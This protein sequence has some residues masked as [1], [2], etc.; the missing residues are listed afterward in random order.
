MSNDSNVKKGTEYEQFVQT[1][2]QSILVAEGVENIVVQH[3]IE[4]TGRSGCTHQMDVY[5]E[6]R[7]AGQ[8]YRTAIECKAF[9]QDV[10]IGRVR[11]FHGVLVDV[12][13]LNGV[14]ATL[15]GYQSGAKRYAKYYGI[16]LQE[17][18]VPNDS[19]WDGRMRDIHVTIHIVNPRITTF[20][21]RISAAFRSKMSPGESLQ[22]Q[23]SGLAQDPIIFDRAGNA[24]LSYEELRRSLPAGL[25]PVIGRTHFV[26]L[27]GH[28]LR[29]NGVDIDIDGI[30]VVYDVDVN[31]VVAATLGQELI[32]AVI[33][34][35]ESGEIKFIPKDRSDR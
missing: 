4:L 1:V 32:R 23:H 8:V 28:V 25:S 34:D 21:P 16:S 7:L 33:K 30:D 13:G 5:W 17:I 19:D 18:R 2:Y 29:I 15:V 6:F 35:V 3:N 14:V 9:D 20:N 10:P 31:T 24:K 27:A 11:D 26:D 22:L 12:P